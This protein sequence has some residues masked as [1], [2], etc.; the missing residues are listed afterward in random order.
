ML[1]RFVGHAGASRL[2]LE[3]RRKRTR[4]TET[5]FTS[6]RYMGVLLALTLMMGLFSRVVGD[7]VKPKSPA[8]QQFDKGVAQLSEKNYAQAEARKSISKK[9]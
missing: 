9:N 3:S 4:L 6:F 8:Q 7:D 2:S 1:S 5:M